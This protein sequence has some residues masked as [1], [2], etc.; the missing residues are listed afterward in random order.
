[1]LP[2]SSHRPRRARPGKRPSGGHRRRQ[3]LGIYGSTDAKDSARA[4]R[5]V[6]LGALRRADLGA[7]RPRTSVPRGVFVPP[8]GALLASIVPAGSR[9]IAGRLSLYVRPWALSCDHAKGLPSNRQRAWLL[10]WCDAG[11]RRRSRPGDHVPQTCHPSSRRCVSG[12]GAIL[13][14]QSLMP[15]SIAHGAPAR[16]GSRG[17]RRALGSTLIR[18]E[19]RSRR[20]HGV[21]LAGRRVR[22]RAVRAADA[23]TRGVYVPTSRSGRRRVKSVST[24]GRSCSSLAALDAERRARSPSLRFPGASITSSLLLR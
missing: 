10:C 17:H 22:R 12:L 1:V 23:G 11:G 8:G 19:Q 21:L 5:A 3:A 4:R 13:P 7:L 24:R 2:V 20:S 18:L 9:R 14:T 16:L 15:S 6:L